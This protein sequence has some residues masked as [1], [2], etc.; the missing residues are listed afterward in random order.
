MSARKFDTSSAFQP[1]TVQARK[2][3][4][5][6]AP[7]QVRIRKNGVEFCSNTPIATWTEM[8]VTLQSTRDTGR[9]HCN[10]VVVACIG[11]RH[12][13]YTVSMVFTNLSRQSQA[14]LNLLAYS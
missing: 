10:G 1:V 5:S 8:T 3:R 11:S 4:L 13:G 6:L 2:T 9:V 14:R 7:D 12:D